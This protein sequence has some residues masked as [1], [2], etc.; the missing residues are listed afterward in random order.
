[1]N[2]ETNVQVGCSVRDEDVFIIQSGCG[3]GAVNDFVMELFILV[4]AMKI[5]S[6]KRVVAVI[7]YFPYSKQ[8]KQ[9]KRGTISA[10]LM[11]E[12]LKVSGVDHVLTMYGTSWGLPMPPPEPRM[13]V[14]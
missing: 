8:S 9:K 6:A 10:K 11:A 1:M 7:P 14:C 3:E 2:K 4:N 5:A 13:L 12:L